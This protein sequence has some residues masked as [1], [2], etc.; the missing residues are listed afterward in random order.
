[1]VSISAF[2]DGVPDPESARFTLADLGVMYSRTDGAAKC[3]AFIVDVHDEKFEL[4]MRTQC[5]SDNTSELIVSDEASILD[6][7]EVTPS[8][9]LNVAGMKGKLGGSF[10]KQDNTDTHTL[11]VIQK[12][13]ITV[14][15]IEIKRTRLS[16]KAFDESECEKLFHPDL[17]RPEKVD[18]FIAEFGDCF[19]GKVVK[20]GCLVRRFD[21]TFSNEQSRKDMKGE[22]EALFQKLPMVSVDL[23]GK[24]GKENKSSSKHQTVKVSCMSAGGENGV[25]KTTTDMKEA[26]SQLNTW[27]I[28][29]T[30]KNSVV[31]SVALYNLDRSLL[32]NMTW[33]GAEL[34]T[35]RQ[36]LALAL[37]YLLELTKER[38]N[39]EAAIEGIRS[40]FEKSE[41][42]RAEGATAIGL[43]Q[44]QF[45]T[46]TQTY[47]KQRFAV[48]ESYLR[49]PPK[50]ILQDVFVPEP[51]RE[52]DHIRLMELQGKD[53]K[54]IRVN[55][56]SRP[57]AAEW[58]GPFCSEEKSDGTTFGVF[59]MPDQVDIYNP[60]GDRSDPA[61]FSIL[62]PGWD[63]VKRVPRFGRE[64]H[65]RVAEQH[66]VPCGA[67]PPLHDLIPEEM[68]CGTV[69]GS[70][71]FSNGDSYIGQW[72]MGAVPVPAG[73]GTMKYAD[74]SEYT[75]CWGGGKRDGLGT[76]RQNRVG[77]SR[78]FQYEFT[79]SWRCGQ[80][81]GKGM[82]TVNQSE[83]EP[84]KIE[85]EW[86]QGVFACTE[87]MVGENAWAK[88]LQK[89][90]ALK[91][92][93]E[94]S[95]GKWKA[96]GVKYEKKEGVEVSKH[97]GTYT[98]DYLFGARHGSGRFLLESGE[99]H[100]G[101]WQDDQFESK[102][103]A[104]LK[105]K[106]G[107]YVGEWTRF[108][109]YVVQANS[110]L[111]SLEVQSSSYVKLSIAVR[112]DWGLLP[113]GNIDPE[114]FEGHLVQRAGELQFSDGLMKELG[115]PRKRGREGPTTLHV[116]V[117]YLP[118]EEGGPA[119]EAKGHVGDANGIPY[120][121]FKPVLLKFK[122]LVVDR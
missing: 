25:F 24:S 103:V 56:G 111:V 84:T 68:R 33:S 37:K 12:V 87:P 13:K 73:E 94:F 107:Y 45:D 82:Q 116:S 42:S 27:K 30:P 41:M 8:L 39:I 62:P 61:M 32:P 18:G 16:S 48:C 92:V 17:I 75:G 31:V 113:A 78:K 93:P 102:V 15:T 51:I 122:G 83:G 71:T 101:W 55:I 29:V 67:S 79:G 50:S 119:F 20:G 59:G 88:A 69:E 58:H 52:E 70:V 1:M 74:G 26:A 40:A 19:I 2:E 64:A 54:N 91:E 53:K 85:G 100:D 9:S 10:S 108:L 72:F 97:R 112:K 109:N 44:N 7:L 98:G 43:V 106:A 36:N 77:Q 120:W 104:S 63:E 22:V 11:T 117:K 4:T 105:I 23:Q 96:T 99:E 89:V 80:R 6:F 115:K 57:F 118:D 47:F 110:L 95:E 14:E 3:A 28:S 5:N 76:F 66:Q 60:D 86:E 114:T 38:V 81:Q 49:R 34:A 121:Q 21:Y 65:I 90:N 46:I 35:Y